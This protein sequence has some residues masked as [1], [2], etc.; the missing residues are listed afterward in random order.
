M[1]HLTN[2]PRSKPLPITFELALRQEHAD[3]DPRYIVRQSGTGGIY[4]IVKRMPMFGEWYSS[5]GTQ[6]G[7]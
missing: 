7:A 4:T 6:H 1:H 2:P 3:G 5:D